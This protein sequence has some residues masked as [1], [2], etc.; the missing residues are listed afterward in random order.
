MAKTDRSLIQLSFLDFLLVGMWFGLIAG[1]AEAVG[2]LWF[3]RINWENWGRTLHVSPPILWISPAVDCI[4]FACLASAV[5]LISRILPARPHLQ[6]LIFLLTTAS[7]YDWLAL[8]DRLYLAACL[9]VAVGVGVVALRWF[10]GHAGMG[11]RLIRSTVPLI[12]LVVALLFVGVQGG[13]WW[14]EHHAVANL[15]EAS[16]GAPNVLVVIFDALRADH[17]SAYGYS[18]P[19]TPEIDHLATQGVRFEAAI[20]ASSWS[21]PS[22]ASLVTGR[23]QYE[24]GADTAK[25]PPLLR[26]PKPSF[27][28]YPM[29]GEEL[30]KLGYRTGAFSGNRVFFTQ[31]DGFA[32]GFQHFEDY[33]QSAEDAIL[34]TLYG[35]ELV[36]LY[37]LR[38]GRLV[39]H[40]RADAVNRELLHWIDRDRSRPFLAYLNYF[41]VHDPYGGPSSYPNPSWP[42]RTDTDEYDA[43]VRYDDAML[44]VL[45][46]QLEARGILNNT[47]V[48]V[49]ADHGESLGQHALLTHSRALYWELIHVP[50]VVSYPGHVPTGTNILWPVSNA[51]IPATVMDMLAH[52][53]QN[54]FPGPPLS[55]AWQAPDAGANWPAPLSELAR[56][57]YPE[58]EEKLAD[59]IEPTSTTG[60]MASIVTPRWHFILHSNFGTQ[61]YDRAHD[62]KEETDLSVTPEGEQ[63]AAQ[64][65]AYLPR[66]VAQYVSSEATQLASA[67]LLQNGTFT[68]QPALNAGHPPVNDYYRVAVIPGTKLKIQVKSQKLAHGSHL[69][70]VLAIQNAQLEPLR[71]CRNPGD[72]HLRAPAISDKTPSAYDDL[73]INDDV[74]P[75]AVTDSSL[76]LLVPPS[77][78]PEVELY[79]HVLQW[80]VLTRGREDYEIIVNGAAT[81]ASAKPAPKETSF[82]RDAAPHLLN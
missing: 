55:R 78:H 64:L 69:D 8:T 2:L 57:P 23:Y 66:K 24:H 36:Q 15:P 39:L 70:P 62:P 79:V 75:G 25:P 41:D 28:G 7:I 38:H 34:R 58:K 14:R 3:Q 5:F 27:R 46:H 30:S 17:V 60:A 33:F 26:R 50:L 11:V 1:I 9:V 29:L 67:P 49:T 61:L 22:H 42:L 19:T 40:K 6:W 54:P 68:S 74:K 20:A 53:S 37:A 12:L 65:A 44:G 81:P 47:I 82:L 76:E 16:A 18:R 13:S 43:G 32:R 77:P 63:A 31:N 51:A 35:R 21:L 56:N 59:Q 72:D 71:T 45:L 73:C 52:G 48:I 10:A 80:N 4:L